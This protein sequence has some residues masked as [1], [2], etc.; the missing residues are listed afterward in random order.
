MWVGW[1]V[2]VLYNSD[3]QQ[4]GREKKKQPEI[5]LSEPS[6]DFSVSG[7]IVK[8]ILCA[9]KLTEDWA[10]RV[11]CEHTDLSFHFWTVTPHRSPG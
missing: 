5:C 4:L 11:G 1:P 10:L 3:F 6:P 8:I 2:L 9:G 7:F